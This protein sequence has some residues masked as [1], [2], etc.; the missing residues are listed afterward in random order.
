MARPGRP[1]TVCTHPQLEAINRDLV[2]RPKQFSAI[3]QKWGLNRKA[4]ARHG[5][6]HL[7]EGLRLAV[8][9]RM[10]ADRQ[11]HSASVKHAELVEE[12]RQLNV[13]ACLGRAAEKGERMLEAVDGWLRDP[14]DPTR[15]NL[16]P[17]A[18]EIQVIWQP[19]GGGPRQKARLSE[20]LE[21][22]ERVTEDYVRRA[23]LLQALRGVE[24]GACNAL[25]ALDALG[26]PALPRRQDVLL[27]AKVADPR[28]LL[29]EVATAFR[30]VLEILGK[31]SG[32]IKAD[33]AAQIAVFVQSPE[34]RAH[35]ERLVELT[36]DC[37]RCGPR[38]VAA[39]EGGKGR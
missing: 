17:R 1:C 3:G 39:L 21:R 33:P 7:T 22:I 29:G 10:E 18:S 9:A 2:S 26:G 30:P 11:I 35:V 32:Q 19:L 12:T 8:L 13:L 34:F 16:D 27:E 15:Y 25:E 6:E 5:S 36:A 4:V 31:A 38:L 14:H 28:K 37:E 24:E 23:D 20:L